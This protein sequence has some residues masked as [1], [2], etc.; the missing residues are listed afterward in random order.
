MSGKSLMMLFDKVVVDRF[1]G[2][3]VK[4]LGSDLIIDRMDVL[5]AF[6]CMWFD[7]EI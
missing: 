7:Q 3:R 6:E 2:S 4:V 5:I 1:G